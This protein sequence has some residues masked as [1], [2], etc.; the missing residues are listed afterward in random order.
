MIRIS[1]G[2]LVSRFTPSSF[3]MR[4]ALFGFI[5]ML[6]FASC[7]P[8]KIAIKQAQRDLPQGFYA[9]HG[10][11]LGV[12]FSGTED[13]RVIAEVATWLGTPY[14]YGGM[15]RL[16]VDCSAF[17]WLVY[18]DAYGYNLPRSS[19]EMA[20]HSRRISQSRLRTGDLV[21]FR[22]KGWKISHV[23]IYLTDGR[24]IH[25]STSSGVIVSSL[26]EPYYSRTFRYGGR[27]RT[28]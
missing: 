25:T 1:T 9:E 2:S 19:A 14:R 4:K 27:V 22:T 17:V 6:L 8:L 13:P 7:S 20:R 28:W 21:F 24:F 10:R 11:M 15:N 23:G 12:R 18:R 16:G 5:A 3:L 26:G